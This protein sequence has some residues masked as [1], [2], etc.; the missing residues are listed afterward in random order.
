ME[1]GHLVIVVAEGAGSGV[2]DLESL[3]EAAQVD[4]SGNKKLSVTFI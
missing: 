3:K 4:E 1:K 2:Q